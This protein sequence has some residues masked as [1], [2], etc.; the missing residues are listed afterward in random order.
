MMHTYIFIYF[1]M[2]WV[3]D[4]VEAENWEGAKAA[5]QA[6]A[7]GGQ[8]VMTRII[9]GSGNEIWNLHT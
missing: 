2:G 4:S 1:A 9:D 8:W 6:A 3:E 5:I 7:G